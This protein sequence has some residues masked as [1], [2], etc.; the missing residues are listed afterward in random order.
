MVQ[1]LVWFVLSNHRSLHEVIFVCPTKGDLLAKVFPITITQI[2]SEEVAFLAA[3]Q[4]SSDKG[5]VGYLFYTG[6]AKLPT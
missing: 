6:D 3:C 2:P 1:Y 4:M 5:P